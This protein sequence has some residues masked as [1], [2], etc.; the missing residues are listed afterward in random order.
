MGWKYIMIEDKLTR[1]LIIFP[2][3]LVHQ[4]VF[5][6]CRELWVPDRLPAVACSA[7]VIEQLRVGGVGGKSDTLRIKS[8]LRDANIIN[9]Y[10]YFHGI[11]GT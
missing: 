2:D 6:V 8:H 10:P 11:K 3:K 9:G 7:G 5:V 1:T 4:E